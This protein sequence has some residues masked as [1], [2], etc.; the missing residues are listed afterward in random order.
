MHLF[1][2]ILILFSSIQVRVINPSLIYSDIEGL[3][4]STTHNILEFRTYSG[5]FFIKKYCL[6]ITI[7]DKNEP[8]EL[9]V[10]ETKDNCSSPSLIEKKLFQKDFYNLHIKYQINLTELKIDQ[11]KVK[12]PVLNHNY[13]VQKIFSHH[14]TINQYGS[15]DL[16]IGLGGEKQEKVNQGE[17]CFQVDDDCQEIKDNCDLCPVGTYYIKANRCSKKYNR[18]CGIDNCGVRGNYACI[19]GHIASEVID[20]CIQDSPMGFCSDGSRVACVNGILI[21]E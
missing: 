16:S 20:Y 5:A 13:R 9:F 19:R 4:P 10:Y 3:P 8:N 11:S 14:E 15:F 1:Q 2:L 17:V 6:G 7:A 18:V 21:C 12:I